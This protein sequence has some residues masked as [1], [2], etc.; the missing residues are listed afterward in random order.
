MGPCTLGVEVPSFPLKGPSVRLHV[1]AR[2]RAECIKVVKF[3]LFSS[4]QLFSCE[5]QVCWIQLFVPSALT[6]PDV[7]LE[8][9][10]VVLD[11]SLTKLVSPQTRYAQN[12]AQESNV[13]ADPSKALLS[14]V[15]EML[16]A[17]NPSRFA[18]LNTLTLRIF[19]RG[20]RKSPLR[21]LKSSQ[22]RSDPRFA[23]A[24]LQS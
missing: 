8:V 21:A 24:R 23:L 5:F 15:V 2:I 9:L 11:L 6:L 7:F 10:D 1:S 16:Q 17:G 4:W 18:H 19:A 3:A 14:P 22:V 13:Y 12:L 20:I